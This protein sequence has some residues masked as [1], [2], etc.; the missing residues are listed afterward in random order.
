MAK[1]L[2]MMSMRASET[3]LPLPAASN[4]LSSA[5]VGSHARQYVA[6]ARRRYLGR[7]AFSCLQKSRCRRRRQYQH[8]HQQQ[9]PKQG[10]H[11]CFTQWRPQWFTQWPISAAVVRTITTATIAATVVAKIQNKSNNGNN[12]KKSTNHAFS[13]WRHQTS[14][15]LLAKLLLHRRSS[16]TRLRRTAG[17]SRRRNGITTAKT[18]T[19]TKNNSRT[20]NTSNGSCCYGN[21]NKNTLTAF[22]L[23][24]I[25]FFT[26]LLASQTSSSMAN[27]SPQKLIGT[28]TG[29]VTIGALFPIREAP[30]AKNAQTRTCGVIRE[31][32]GIHR[33]EAAFQTLDEINNNPRLLPNI[34]LGIE[35]RDSC[36]YSPTALE[37]SIEFIRDTIAMRDDANTSTSAGGATTEQCHRG[38]K[39]TKN[40]VGIIGPGSSAVTIQ[41]Q[42][43]L[44]LFNIPQIGYSA[45][46]RE[47]SRKDFYKYFLRV[48]P[49]D[50]FQAKLMVDV[51]LKFNW[52]YVITI[53]TEGNYGHS[54]MEVFATRAK[55]AGICVATQDTLG[56][57]AEPEEYD[58]LL[59]SLSEF[60]SAKVIVCFCEGFTVHHLIN[61]TARLNM[62]GKYVIFGSDGWSDRMDVVANLERHATGS[63]SVRLHTNYDTEFDQYYFGLDPFTNKRNPWFREFWETRF[64]CSFRNTNSSASNKQTGSSRRKGTRICNGKEK[65]NEGGKYKQD[66]KL[67]FV[68]KSIYTM[69]YG[70]HNMHRD[71]CPNRTGLCSAMLP[72]NGSIFLQ[73]LM[74]VSF[75]W[76]TDG[77]KVFFMQN[78]D[79]PGQY[80][81]MNF[82]QVSPDKYDYVQV[83]AWVNGILNLTAPIQWSPQFHLKADSPPVSICS[84]PCPK[85]QVKNVHSETLKCCWTC[86]EC[87]KNEYVLDEYTCKACALGY[88]PNENLTGCQV[89]PVEYIHWYDTDS[90]VAISI[91]VCGII[92]TLTVMVIF[93]CH[94]NTPVV[95]SST[96]ELSYI[97]MV[98]MFACYCS[99]FFLI[100]YP[101]VLTCSFTRVLPG[102]SFAMMYA[103]LVTKT[104]RIACILAGSKKKIITKKPRFM[105]ASAQVV[106]TLLLIGVEVGIIVTLIVFEPPDAKYDYPDLSRVKIICNTTTLGIIAPL[107]FDFFLIAMCTVY[108][109]KTRNVPENFNEAKFIGFT[110]YTTLVIWMAFVPIYFGSK[111][112]VITLCLCISFSALVA[113][114]LLFLPKVYIILFRPEKNN[115]SAFTTAKDV[116]CHIGYINSNV[117]R[118]SSHSASEFSMGSPRNYSGETSG[119]AQKIG[120]R[121]SNPPG[122]Q[123]SRPQQRKKNLNIFERFRVSKQDRIAASVAQHIRAVRAAEALDRNTRFR[124]SQEPLFTMDAKPPGSSAGVGGPA[125]H[126]ATAGPRLPPQRS[127]SCGEDTSPTGALSSGG[128][129]RKRMSSA[130][131][132]DQEHVD[133]G[134][135]T[136]DDLVEM[137]L[138]C[139]R[140]RIVRHSGGEGTISGGASAGDDGVNTG[141]GTFA[142]SPDHD[143]ET[144]ATLR[145]RSWSTDPKTRQ[146]ETGPGQTTFMPSC[147]TQKDRRDLGVLSKE[148][149]TAVLP[150]QLG[151]AG[152]VGGT[153]GRTEEGLMESSIV[154][155]SVSSNGDESSSAIYKNIIINLGSPS[156]K[157]A[158][159]ISTP[160][161]RRSGSKP[162]QPL[163]EHIHPACP[164]HGDPLLVT[165]WAEVSAQMLLRNYHESQHRAHSHGDY[166]WKNTIGRSASTKGCRHGCRHT[167]VRQET[168]C[169]EH[170]DRKLADSGQMKN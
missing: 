61:A 31:Q 129:S 102:L 64:N 116:R 156:C 147:S 148:N 42:N 135:Q 19:A 144:I 54:G 4:A 7:G 90:I 170:R 59:Y 117:S 169:K 78:G 88:W 160:A 36:W 130:Q 53:N 20:G 52:T 16:T 76:T 49:S 121:T 125:G 96:R 123:P 68:K 38:A 111:H 29:D 87:K 81:I 126:G 51:L 48:V 40:I 93:I 162:P 57:N 62:T 24:R 108:A 47:L 22:G 151:Y 137:W 119:G 26:A 14:A 134:C 109:V 74:N 83:G 44:Q 124:H 157:T 80:D 70:L 150:L 92:A 99:A 159:V 143:D 8:Q 133:I 9:Q 65:L 67:E 103:A 95:K 100:A 141:D 2:K 158:Q 39:N 77:S 58:N 3:S 107:G 60:P 166:M 33:V 165:E 153:R 161:L 85:G 30:D 114:V 11:Q 66:T 56:H 86:T 164:L 25:T 110:M 63:I 136:T 37:Q 35:I 104:N 10:T 105:S 84:N 128:G 46:S 6:T 12:K 50:E 115:R 23:F 145:Q 17:N 122:Q 43:L 98:G 113:L 131:H 149:R 97:I 132:R 112:R 140:R 75:D 45:T 89:I 5:L 120:G 55:E 28:A 138:P 79:P 71:F 72:I 1:V 82:Q 167:H 155:E 139:L 142:G 168:H 41:V 15:K 91:S 27:R 18:T 21:Y 127:S 146:K 73:Y 94:N 13:S 34:T 163:P 106:I 32:Y 154:E 101:S 69:A 118:N 152:A